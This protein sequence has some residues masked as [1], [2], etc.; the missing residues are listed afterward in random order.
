MTNDEQAIRDL[1]S[2]WLQASAAGDTA[3]VLNLMADDVLFLVP[4]MKPFGKKEFTDAQQG[5]AQFRMEG[6]SNVREVQV[7]GD[8]AYCWT[9][10]TVVITPIAGG[11]PIRRSGPTL[12]ILRKLANGRWVLAR[13]ANM[14]TV[15]TPKP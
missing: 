12:S 6:T 3:N 4:G 5:L 10:L 13:D 2:T 15:E 1:I 8:W 11:S 7:T 9:E 14:L